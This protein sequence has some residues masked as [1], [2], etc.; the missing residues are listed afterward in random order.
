MQSPIYKEE[1][2]P[3]IKERQSDT[4]QKITAALMPERNLSHLHSLALITFILKTPT[5]HII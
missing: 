4:P 2:S 1:F 3:A 5:N